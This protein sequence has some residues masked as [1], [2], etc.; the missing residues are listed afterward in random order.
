MESYINTTSKSF[1]GSS[2]DINFNVPLFATYLNML[3]LL[4]AVPAIIIPA[5]LVIRIILTTEKLHTI[6]YLFV[7]HLLAADILNT[8]KMGFEVILMCL[9][10]FGINADTSDLHYLYHSEYPSTSSTSFICQS[11]Y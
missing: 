5:V 3:F 4:V 1:N 8:L 10:L 9:F 7:I 6:Y 11:S 2:D